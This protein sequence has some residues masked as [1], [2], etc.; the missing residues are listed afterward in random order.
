MSETGAWTVVRTPDDRFVELAGYPWAPNYTLVEAR[1]IAPV[2]MHYVEA[3]P[4]TGDVV[5]LLHGHPTWSYLYRKVIAALA[6][7]GWRVLAPDLIGYGR[8]DK[9]TERTDYTFGRHVQWMSSFVTGLDLHGVTLVV[10]D[11]GG[12]IGLSTLAGHPERF[13]RVV[14][15]NTVLH[16]S[17]PSLVGRLA[18]A[19]HGSGETTVTLE[20]ALVDYVASCWRARDLVPSMFIEAV[21]GPLAPGVRAAYDA[22]FPGPTFKAGLR[23]MTGLI[24]LTRNDPGAVIGRRTFAALGEWD[25]PFLTAFSDGDPATRGW[26]RVLRDRIPGA[27]GQPHVTIAGAGHFVPEEKGEE[28]ARIVASFLVAT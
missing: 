15:T 4:P 7:A 24:P 26:E 9:L 14:A 11:W 27:R 20:E 25:R 21:T 2:R 22:P 3:G 12:P 18:W 1:R 8:S 19:N 16:T 13:S 23:Q 10:H 17:D 6:D 5:L 28:L